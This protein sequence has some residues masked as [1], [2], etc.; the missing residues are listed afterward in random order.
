MIQQAGMRQTWVN[1][2]C[3]GWNSR[4]LWILEGLHREVDVWCGHQTNYDRPPGDHTGTLGE[5]LLV[6]EGL[7][8]RAFASALLQKQTRLQSAISAAC[9]TCCSIHLATRL[10]SDHHDLWQFRQRVLYIGLVLRQRCKRSL[11]LASDLQQTIHWFSQ[12]AVGTQLDALQTR[13]MGEKLDFATELPR[14]LRVTSSLTARAY[15]ASRQGGESR[16]RFPRL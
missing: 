14:V 13:T 5:E 2:W 7:Q 16:S 9:N 15:G 6:D 12:L 4:G 3:T 8:Q 1:N 11:D 10:A